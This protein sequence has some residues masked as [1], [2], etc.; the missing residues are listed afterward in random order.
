MTKYEF[1]R[2]MG[3]RLQQLSSGAIPFV[4]YTT[5][6]TIEAIFLRE[7]GTGLLPFLVERK[8]PDGQYIFIKIRQF[9]NREVIMLE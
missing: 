8:T 9:S 2:V 6:D 5:N 7:F 1:A 4:S 3:E